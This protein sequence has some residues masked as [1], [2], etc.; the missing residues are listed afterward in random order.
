[1]AFVRVDLP[2]P[3]GSA[4]DGLAGRY[5]SDETDMTYTVRVVDGQLRL[6]WPRQY[7]LAL[8]AVGGDRFIGARGTVTFTRKPSGEVDGLT[9]SN[10]RL[11]RF[12]AE[13]VM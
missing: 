3:T 13:R 10:R 9:I 4:L 8:E 1:R 2:I 11:R 7:D 6:T 12:R 5:R